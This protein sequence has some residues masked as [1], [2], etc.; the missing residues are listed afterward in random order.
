MIKHNPKGFTLIEVMVVV[1]ILSILAV[2]VVPKI[3]DKPEQARKTQVK[4]NLRILEQQ[5]NIYKLDNAH[6]PSTDQGLAALVTKPSG[7]PEPKSWNKEGYINRIP[8]DPWGGDYQ[9][10]YPGTHG[11]IDIFTL[12]PDGVPSDDDIGN[13]DLN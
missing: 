9:Y 7:S 11:K 4:Q 8:K 2:F 12:G 1:V 6:Y 5:L 3:M 10:L 13:W